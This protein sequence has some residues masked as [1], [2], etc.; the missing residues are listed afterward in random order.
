MCDHLLKQFIEESFCTVPAFRTQVN[1]ACVFPNERNPK[2][3]WLGFENLQFLLPA[4]SQMGE[5]LHRNGFI[6]ENKP[7]KPHLT[8]ARIKSLE[9]GDGFKSFL[10]L[11]RH[12]TFGTVDINRVILYE[13][14]LK[15]AG[16]VYK[17]LFVKD[18]ETGQ[19]GIS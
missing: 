19:N 18:L 2:V 13:S 1:R 17:P 11:N 7:M 5:L 12:L 15:P 6:L 4:C 8:L 3:L 14:I 10:T 9:N 16:P